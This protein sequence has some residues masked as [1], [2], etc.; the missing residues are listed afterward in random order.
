MVR[1]R[2]VG[3][4]A[5]QNK[6]G[7]REKMYG[8]MRTLLNT[9][10]LHWLLICLWTAC[11]RQT[12]PGPCQYWSSTCPG[13]TRTVPSWGLPPVISADTGWH[14]CPCWLGLPAAPLCGASSLVE[15]EGRTQNNRSTFPSPHPSI[16]SVPDPVILLISCVWSY[17]A[18]AG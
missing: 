14:S 9:K 3:V 5:E 8:L 6:E 13:S 10:C 7:S 4:I 11:R 18:A 2:G 1:G 12:H 15:G 17:L 16:Y